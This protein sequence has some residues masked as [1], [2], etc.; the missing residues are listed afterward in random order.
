MGAPTEGHD[1]R[2]CGD[3]N[4]PRYACQLYW[5]GR[6]DGEHLG[7]ERGHAEGY[8]AGYKQGFS[9]GTVACPRPHGKR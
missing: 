7:Y 8:D 6:Q 1:Y 4:C 2:R 9:D 3:V 5:E